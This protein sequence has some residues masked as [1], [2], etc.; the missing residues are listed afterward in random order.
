MIFFSLQL[1]QL[2]HI[3]TEFNLGGFDKV[4][5]EFTSYLKS[6]NNYKKNV[7]KLDEDIINTIDKHWGFTIDKWNYELPEII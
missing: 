7:Y 1:N 3:Y 6:V 2:S 5:P 4:K